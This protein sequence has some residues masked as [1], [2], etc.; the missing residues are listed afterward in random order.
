M[1]KILFF[2]CERNFEVTFGIFLVLVAQINVSENYLEIFLL[3]FFE[4]RDKMA[5]SPYIF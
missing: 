5:I 1:F 2:T 3:N 4:M